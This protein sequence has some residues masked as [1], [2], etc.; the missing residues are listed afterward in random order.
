MALE[1]VESECWCTIWRRCH[2]SYKGRCHT[3]NRVIMKP[4]S[5]HS[6]AASTGQLETARVRSTVK[7]RAE[8]TEEPAR[9]IVQAAMGNLSRAAQAT[10]P[11]TETIKRNIR[12]YRQLPPQINNNLSAELRLN[13]K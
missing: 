5:Q 11:K 13:F 7:R 8:Q 3:A 9:M 4:T 2:R 6:H 12:R 10:V 1:F